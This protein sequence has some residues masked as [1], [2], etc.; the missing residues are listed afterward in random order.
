MRRNETSGKLCHVARVERVGVS[1]RAAILQWVVCGCLA[2]LPSMVAAQ[3]AKDGAHPEG[4]WEVLEGCRLVTNSIVDGDSFH[5]THK[6]R[7]YIFRLYF[8]DAPEANPAIKERVQDQSAYFGISVTNVPRA[9]MV[10]AKFSREKLSGRDFTV[11]TRWQ[12]AMGR[13]TLA[14]F[15]AVVLVKG[16]NLAE[17][18][19]ANG[20]A[21]IYGLRANW[22]DGPRSATFINKLKNLELTAREKHRGVWDETLF[23]RGSDTDAATTATTGKK[24]SAG[25]MDLNEASFEELQTLPGIGPVLAQR[26]IAHRPYHNTD[27]LLK[28]NGVGD[29]TLERLKPLIGIKEPKKDK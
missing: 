6:G 26:I 17:D 23:P 22:P 29:K 5:V 11:V 13:S 7:E 24:G 10:A 25:T 27:D 2:L 3:Q 16:E 9:G 8:I 14:R 18:L 28:I 4:K 15:Y 20:L 21:R 19:V 12:N 1:V